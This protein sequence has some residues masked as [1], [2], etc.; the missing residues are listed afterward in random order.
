M[1]F[2]TVLNRS[3]DPRAVSMVMGQAGTNAQL[4]NPAALKEMRQA[5]FKVEL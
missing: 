2:G 4:K 5:T 1:K 3:L